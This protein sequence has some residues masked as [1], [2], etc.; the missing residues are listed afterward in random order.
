MRFNLG[1]NEDDSWRMFGLSLVLG[2]NSHALSVALINSRAL[3]LN[4]NLLNFFVLVDVIFPSFVLRLMVG[5]ACFWL[6][7]CDVI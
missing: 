6:W 5:H 4:L 7:F 3:A 1:P 2:L